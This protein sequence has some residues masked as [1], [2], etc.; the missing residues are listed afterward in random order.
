MPEVTA[1]SSGGFVVAFYNDNY[2]V[3]ETGTQNDVYIREYDAAGNAVDGQRKLVSPDN[4]TAYQPVVADL[5][6]G[7]FAVIYSSY[8]TSA[9][10]GNN[11]HE[12]RQQLSATPPSWRA[13]RARSWRTSPA[14]S[15]S[16]RTTVNAGLQVIDAAVGLSDPDSANFSGGRLDLFYLQ[17]GSAEDQLGVVHQGD[18][19]GQIGVA[20]NTVSYG[21]VAIGTISGGAD[22]ANL[23]IDFTSTAA[24]VEAVEALIQ[25][26]GYGNDDQ[27]PNASRTL[28]L[29]VSDGD[30]GTS[31]PNTLTI[32]VSSSVDGAPRVW[33]EEVVNTWTASAQEWPA[34]ATLVDGSYVVAWQ[35]NGNQDGSGYGIYAQRFAG[36]GEAIGPE[37]RV[38]TL[39]GGDQSWAQVAALS[40]GGFVIT[41]QDSAGND[42][43]GYGS[44][45]Q[46][47]D[48]AGNAQGGQL[49]LNTTTSGTQ[50]HTNVAAYTG[51]FAA[52][53]SNGSDIFLQRFA[54]DGTKAGGETLVSTGVGSA[55][56][57]G[58][59]VPARHRS[60][61]QWRPGDRVGRRWRQRRQLLRSVRALVRRRHRDLRQQ[62]PGQHGRPPVTRAARA[63]TTMRRRCPRS[64]AA[65]SSSCGRPTTRTAAAPGRVYGQRFD[66]AGNKL[67][68]EFQVNE[69]T[70][71]GQYV[72]EVTGLSDGG[73]VVAFY[74][75]NY[76]VSGS[77][78][79]SDVYIRE[80]DAAGN[81]IDGQRKLESPDN[82]TAY[83]PVVAD[84]GSGNFAVIYSSYATSANG[85]NNT[86]EIRQQLFGDAAELARSASPQLGDFAG[87]V[88]FVENDVNAALQLID[89]AV[90]LSDADSA[91][92]AGGRL[93]LYYVQGGSAEDQLGVVH[94][95]N[96]A[97]EIGV[98]GSTVRYGGAAIGTISGGADG[99]NLRIDFTSAAATVEAVE[100]LIERLGYKN[101]D[102]SP[103][104]SRTLGLRVSDGDGGTS[105][106]SMLSVVV[107]PSLDGTPQVWAEELVNT[108]TPST[109]AWPAA[110]TLAD[111]SYVV[112]WQSSGQD[113]GSWGIYA[114]RFANNGEALGAEVRVN[115]LVNGE[116][117]WPQI[118]A[119]SNGGFV[120]SW[121][122][123]GGNDGSGWGSYAQRFDAAGVA[124]GGQLLLNTTTSG[125]QYHTNVAA[126][127]GGFAAVWSNGSDI[128]LQRF[129]NAG[130][131][132][133]LETLVSTVPG[134]ASA[135]AGAQYVPD[136]AGRADGDLVVVW[137]DSG[138]N[139]GNSNGVF[140][141][142]YDAAT[143][144]FGSTFLVNTTTTGQQ[145]AGNNGDHAPNVAILADGGFVVVWSAYDQD[146]ASTWGVYGQRFDA[147][148]VKVGGEFRV[149]ETTAGGQY[150]AEVT[151]LSTGGFVVSFYNDHYDESG[152]GTTS[153]VYIREYDA[154][155]NAIDGQRKLESPDN[156]TAYQPVVADLGSGNFAVIYSSYAT[157]ANGGNNT[158]EIRQQLF[159][160]AAELARPSADPV[161]DDLRGTLTLSYDNASPFYAGAARALDPDVLIRDVDSTDFGGGSLIVQ[162]LD[163][164]PAAHANETLAIAAAGPI[165]VSGNEVS[166]GGT[167]IGTFSGGT[168]GANLVVSFDADATAEAVQALVQSLTYVNA[169]P[170]SSQT[171]RY[172]GFRLFD[173]DGGAAIQQ[174][175]L[176]RIQASVSPPTVDLQDLESAVTLT[177]SAAQVGVVLDPGVQ[178][179]Y[180]GATGFNAGSLTVS[181]VSSSG[182][183]EDQLSI[184][185]EG[186]GAGQVGVSGADVSYGGTLI[187]TIA[188]ADNGANG[189]QLVINFNA[190]ASAEAIERVLEN[191]SYRTSSDGPL[192]AR[193]IQV[194]VRDGAGVAS[195][196]SQ[197][198]INVTPE[199]DGASPLFGEQQANTYEADYQIAPVVTGLQG[200]NVGGYVVV[201]RSDGA[202]DGSGYGLYGQRYDAKGAALGAEF[203]VNTYAQSN[204]YEPEIASLANGGFVV[205]WRSS[206]Q[207]G[208]GES[209]HA[210][211]YGADGMAVGGEFR[212]NTSIRLQPVRAGGGRPVGRQLRRR[213]PQRLHRT[214]RRATP[215]TCWPS[216]TRPTARCWLTSSPSTPRSRVPSSTRAWPRCPGASS[217]RST[218]MR[219]ATTVA[220]TAVFSKVFN[221]DGTVAVAEQVVPSTVA[222]NQYGH[223]VAVLADGG[224]VV[225]WWSCRRPAS[226]ASAS[227]PTG[228]KARRPVP[229]EYVRQRSLPGLCARRRARRRRLRGRL[230]QLTNGV[231]GSSYDVFIQ[232]FDAAGNKVDGL[233]VANAN[234]AS[235]QYLPDI[236]G[237]H[238]QQL[239]GGVGELQPG[240]RQRQQLRCIHPH[241]R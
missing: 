31:N 153:D 54:N 105:N 37:F 75:D 205:V 198:V 190:S 217:S 46:R 42:G 137:S 148:G 234:I 98:D 69:T 118:A 215:T 142:I 21:G 225:V 156:G 33:A 114:Q 227:T 41:W 144:S 188:A 94:E 168:A 28:G 51:G 43:S 95:G 8:A 147:A 192:A 222:G 139:D 230:G 209:V 150:Q 53:W 58:R 181:Y 223:D 9:N 44:F 49:L 7:N 124:Q 233:V 99:A 195:S 229:G 196:A 232:Q 62:L 179:A 34:T 116:Q 25:R 184:R 14:R 207:D 77:G 115:T 35:S 213:L 176:V 32:T 151:A 152:A 219:A 87:T 135:Q 149:N 194:V 134:G 107:S 78:T 180:N 71:G 112:A 206:G 143:D 86:H 239:C 48:A 129:D 241:V 126:Y 121:Q 125:T 171:D 55:P 231:G 45:G 208:S 210:Q 40:D 82:G 19:A 191:L 22:G 1:L 80:Y 155:G 167:V 203:Q 175:M 83:Q 212:V 226:T 131:K 189:D 65:A 47:F 16:S 6:S 157:S 67:G 160:D 182:R 36:N 146:S 30:G 85:G 141:R 204:Q 128:Y 113:G 214:R 88:S 122:D 162:F 52:V 103:N 15:A 39:T 240:G 186:S 164:G 185:N 193:T 93:D 161:L 127:P 23:R 84:L 178:L 136:V 158:H 66:A 4:S 218:A 187:G 20:G 169:A 59:P 166:Y 238:R 106:T 60:G 123:N 221:A 216:A 79:T 50:Y 197:M 172:L 76:D 2:D 96:D 130:T 117:S 236:A 56:R 57:N 26:L 109:Q 24:T 11:T 91:N 199:L 17:G 104:A 120:V 235:A 13:R 173:G 18:G 108:Y 170:G 111:G 145:S 90:G 202:Q 174:Q 140:A 38:N 5:G 119:L 228:A 183:S 224:Y 92:F 27:N 29:R 154:A 64:R 74:N 220:A 101:T 72:S 102:V 177:E 89:A 10:G 3:S 133:G 110:A 81:A 73:F 70:A 100:A 163:G 165:A 97:G 237:A 61:S 201:W 200:A 132:Q 159:G 68:G 138:G 12:I 63:T 211:I